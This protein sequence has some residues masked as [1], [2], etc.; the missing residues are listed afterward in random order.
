MI[1]RLSKNTK[2]SDLHEL[3]DEKQEVIF[4]YDYKLHSY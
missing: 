3:N 4:E 1:G 2:I